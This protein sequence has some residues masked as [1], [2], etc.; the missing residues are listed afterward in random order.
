M[1]SSEKRRYKELALYPDKSATEDSLSEMVKKLD[2]SG[3]SKMNKQEKILAIIKDEKKRKKKSKSKSKSEEVEVEENTDCGQYSKQDLLKKNIEE[4]RKILKTKHSVDAENVEDIEEGVD[5]ICNTQNKCNDDYSCPDDKVC[6]VNT[7]PGLCVNKNINKN[8]STLQYKNRTIVG[9][10]KVI[11]MLK[12]K[13]EK[14][15]E[16]SEEEE[17]VKKTSKQKLADMDFDVSRIKDRKIASE[18]YRQYERHKGKCSVENN[19]ECKKGFQCDITTKP[20]ICIKD[21]RAKKREYKYEISGK[22][23]Y[24][25]VPQNFEDDSGTDVDEPPPRA[26]EQKRDEDILTQLDEDIISPPRAQEQ[27]RVEDSEEDSEEEAEEK[28]QELPKISSKQIE[29]KIQ[30]LIAEERPKINLGEKRN[31][32]FKCLGLLG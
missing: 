8:L 11:D 25:S 1:S 6:N 13:L 21:K 20:G 31:K 16:E 12:Q 30:E 24:S 15:K 9:S 23:V 2:I 14:E 27:K 3:R 29:E 17:K 5:M 26:Q 22:N 7:K 18:L 4:L 10:K 28:I 19:Y 32:V